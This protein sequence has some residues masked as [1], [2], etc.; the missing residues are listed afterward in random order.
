M[1][2]L[3]GVIS[4]DGCHPDAQNNDAL[5]KFR[6]PPKT[7]GKLRFLLG[8]LDHYRAYIK[9]FFRI[10]NPFYDIVVTP[11]SKNGSIDSKQYII[12]E[13]FHQKVLDEVIN[14]LKFS[15]IIWNPHFTHPF[16]IHCDESQK[17]IEAVL[18]QK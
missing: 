4:K 11:K 18:Y 8:F 6:T 16:I 17:G 2:Y 3:G 7:I 5:E 15:E 12:W 13:A 1:I 14:C 9:T 10:M